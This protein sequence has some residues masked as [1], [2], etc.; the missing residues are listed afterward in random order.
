MPFTTRSRLRR[1]RRRHSR[2]R[3]G[4]RRATTG[5]VNRR[6]RRFARSI[7]RPQRKY[8]DNGG[9][10][11]FSGP[12]ANPGIIFSLASN[13]APG[14]PP[15]SAVSQGVSQ[16]QLI[17]YKGQWRSHTYRLGIDT[18][19]TAA[20]PT[21][22]IGIFWRIIFFMWRPN[23]MTPSG[24]G[25]APTALQILQAGNVTSPVPTGAQLIFSP[26]NKEWAKQYRIW[27]DKTY[28]ISIQGSTQII[29][30]KGHRK[31]R[32]T[33]QALQ[34]NGPGGVYDQVPY[35]LLISSQF[36]GGGMVE[37]ALS[38]YNRMTYT[39]F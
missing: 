15:V 27:S 37:T 2:F 31:M 1:P 5:Y 6:L 18:E 34:P 4:T 29:V 17:G 36:S 23:E 11:I 19:L 3:R 26:Y 38:I 9:L 14:T 21:G 39:N 7:P 30:D 28:A 33:F 24:I 20:S 13:S 35:C 8:L 25:N 32:K 12:Q 16:N 22:Q 10:Q